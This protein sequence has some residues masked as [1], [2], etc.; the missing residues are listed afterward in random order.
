MP[1]FRRNLDLS[2]AIPRL[3]GSPDLSRV[4]RLL[5]TCQHRNVSVSAEELPALLASAPAVV[6]SSS[7]AIWAAVIAS[8]NVESTAWIRALAFA[9]GLQIDPAAD[10]LLPLFHTYLQERAVW[11]LF[12]ATTQSSD[13]WVKSALDRQGYVFDTDVIVYEKHGTTIPSYGDRTVRVRHAQAV[14]LAPILAVDAASF[15]PEWHKDE[16]AIG[17]A[18]IYSS[19]FLVAELAEQI[20]GYAFVTSHFGNRM[21]H[22]VRIAV[23]PAYQGH[24]IGVRLLAE[25]I[26]FGQARGA[27]IFTLNTQSYNV[28]ARRL[29][30]W[31][32]F[33]VTGERQVILRRDLPV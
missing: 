33:R 12:Y 2:L 27:N 6:L 22:L 32:E 29:Y 24:G 28:A 26:A 20:V 5:S 23:L 31:F 16:A 15:A 4:A 3:A 10:L 19:C 13:F 7:E 21:I 30:E 11:R 17:P 25:V 1:L 18:L 14:D 8:W 9:D